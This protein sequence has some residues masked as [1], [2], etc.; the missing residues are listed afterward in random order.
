[1]SMFCFQC[2]EA[3]KGTGCT[4]KGVCGKSDDLAQMMDLL[5]YTCKGISV[6]TAEARKAGLVTRSEDLFIMDA[7]FT[8]I[9]NANF[10]KQ[11]VVEKLKKGLELKKSL[12]NRLREAGV[13]L[14]ESQ[15]P[16]AALYQG[17]EAD[18]EKDAES[19]GV[20]STGD[21]D[22]RS[23]RELLIYGVKGMAAYAE[24]AYNLGMEDPSIYQ[25]M[26]EALAATLNDKLSA[27]ELVGLVLDA[28][29][30]GVTTMALLDKANTSRYGN[31]ELTQVNIGTR[32]NPGIL[33]SGHD[34][35]DLEDLMI[36][37]QGKGVDVY[38]H[39]EMLPAHYYPFF[40]KYP[41]FAGNYGSAWWKQKEEF[42]THTLTS[43]QCAERPTC[44]C[45]WQCKY[46]MTELYERE[47]CFHRL[48][49][50]EL[51]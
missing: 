5:V 31:P 13:K 19:R 25:F 4:V 1:M 43:V 28:G 44:Q 51:F 42:E 27:D 17:T 39:S 3:A 16:E 48:F 9:T 35:R 26:Q 38:T 49:L 10:D 15:L 33:I 20:L 37:T 2:Q 34:L 7:L 11:A 24:H 22:I 12:Q 18:F 30:F 14:N 21:P 40:K 47:V 32:N 29:K 50:V 6:F 46:G 45:E 41:N 36:Q 8:T 23:L